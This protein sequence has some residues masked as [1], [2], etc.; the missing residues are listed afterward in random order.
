MPVL[1]REAFLPHRLREL[2]RDRRAW[3]VNRDGLFAAANPR[4]QE[5]LVAMAEWE[6]KCRYELIPR[7]HLFSNCRSYIDQYRMAMLPYTVTGR[8]LPPKPNTIIR[9]LARIDRELAWLESRLAKVQRRRFVAQLLRQVNAVEEADVLMGVCF[10]LS[11]MRLEPDGQLTESLSARI[12]ESFVQKGT[13]ATRRLDR[14][15]SLSDIKVDQNWRPLGVLTS[16][17][18][19]V[20]E[21]DLAAALRYLDEDALRKDRRFDSFLEGRPD[22]LT[23]L[24]LL[25]QSA[26]PALAQNFLVRA[27]RQA[28]H[29]F[30]KC[31]PD[32]VPQLRKVMD[33][34]CETLAQWVL[35]RPQSDAELESDSL[36]C[37]LEYGDPCQAYW[38][39]CLERAWE[40][41]QQKMLEPVVHFQWHRR[42]IEV[43]FYS[44]PGS[45]IQAQALERFDTL[46]RER[47]SR[48]QFFIGE[49]DRMHMSELSAMKL[50]ESSP[51]SGRNRR[52][53]A[54]P[55]HS[56]NQVL[57]RNFQ[58]ALQERAQAQSVDELGLLVDFA[59]DLENEAFSIECHEQIV[60]RFESFARRFPNEAGLCLR[61][62]GRGT[63][64][65][66][67]LGDWQI[68]CAATF[69]TLLPVLDAIS[70]EDAAVAR[71]AENWTSRGNI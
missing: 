27:L 55:D 35:E 46:V 14:V 67:N 25:V 44:P 62:I 40:R 66:S 65:R 56:L 17:L 49:F 15:L 59:I 42:L 69:E 57:R 68:R 12:N 2:H 70:L 31:P 23:R 45:T 41:C 34:S 4:E 6:A 22:V 18:L 58:Q 64:Y 13:P 16:L 1:N 37:L 5:V 61:E 71:S 39:I 3:L 54:A 38:S 63:K 21:Q 60:R 9:S 26:R 48:Y 52:F 11:A 47:L 10:L 30:S 50:L 7:P 19:E 33:A 20:A 28:D 36:Y 29:E 8:E 32:A 43:A 53:Q 24:A 51:Y